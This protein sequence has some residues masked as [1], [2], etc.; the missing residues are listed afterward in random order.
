MTIEKLLECSASI[1]EAM[2][3]EELK[4][5][6]AP[7]LNVTRPENPESQYK[8]KESSPRLVRVDANKSGIKDRISKMDPEKA[9]QLLDM[10]KSVGLDT[11]ELGLKR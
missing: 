10:F 11:K 3:D 5:H 2:S 7:Y 1:L 4:K 8:Q 6:F 9:A